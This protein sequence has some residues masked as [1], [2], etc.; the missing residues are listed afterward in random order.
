MEYGPERSSSLVIAARIFWKKALKH[1]ILEEKMRNGKTSSNCFFLTLKWSNKET[2]IG[3]SSFCRAIDNKIQEMQKISGSLCNSAYEGSITN[4][5][6]DKQCEEKKVE[7]DLKTL[8]KIFKG[9]III[10]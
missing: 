2:F 10:S 8:N 9:M 6:H 3:L 4:L 5:G 1:K 7:L